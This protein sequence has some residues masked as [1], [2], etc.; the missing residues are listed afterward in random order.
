MVSIVKSCHLK[1]KHPTQHYPFMLQSSVRGISGD[2]SFNA[3]ELHAID[4]QLSINC[5]SR[6]SRKKCYQHL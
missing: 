5:E 1:I 6:V 3:P 2:K 4:Y